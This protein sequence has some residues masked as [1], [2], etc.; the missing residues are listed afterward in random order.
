MSGSF[1]FILWMGFGICDFLVEDVVFIFFRVFSVFL[2]R[3]FIEEKFFF[4]YG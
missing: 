4:E 1:V 3:R 2:F